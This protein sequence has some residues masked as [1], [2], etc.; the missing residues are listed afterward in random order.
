MSRITVKSHCRLMQGGRT[1]NIR[2]DGD[3][4]NSTL[5]SISPFG[6]CNRQ[7]KG[8]RRF[9]GGTDVVQAASPLPSSSIKAPVVKIQ[10]WKCVESTLQQ[11]LNLSILRHT[12][13]NCRKIRLI[14]SIFQNISTKIFV[15]LANGYMTTK[16]IRLKVDKLAVAAEQMREHTAV[17]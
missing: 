13:G 2:S 15:C 3:T 6:S 16:C 11:I 10:S 5:H 8:K 17:C 4:N 9:W 7:A 12:D 1:L 14:C